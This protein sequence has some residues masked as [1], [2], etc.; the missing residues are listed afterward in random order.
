[1]R[2]RRRLLRAENYQPL[3][4]YLE[5]QPGPS[6]TLTLADIE[7]LLGRSLPSSARTRAWWMARGRRT[8]YRR[9]LAPLGWT[10]GAVQV[11]RDPPS[12]TFV[13]APVSGEERP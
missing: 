2:P 13:K 5:H 12:I 6:V 9:L 4:E 1:M 10:V 7:T 3:V 8:G 11:R